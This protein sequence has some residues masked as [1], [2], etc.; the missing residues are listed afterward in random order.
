MIESDDYKRGWY[1][2]YQAA[3]RHNP[4]I[5][6]PPITVPTIKVSNVCNVCGIDFGNKAWGYVCYNDKCPTRITATT[7]AGSDYRPMGGAGSNGSAGGS[8]GINF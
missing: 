7:V 1:D 8:N 6:Q 4:T 2:G 3:Q 5:T